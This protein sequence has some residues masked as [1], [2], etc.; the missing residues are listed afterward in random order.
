MSMKGIKS[1]FSFSRKELNGIFLLLMLIQIALMFPFAYRYYYKAPEYDLSGFES[2]VMELHAQIE[3]SK[4]IKLVQNTFVPRCFKFDPNELDEN[5]WKK[6]GVSEGQIKIIL[7]YKARGG[8]FF[9]REDLKR[10]YSISDEQYLKLEP[11]IQI[12]P[13]TISNKSLPAHVKMP[14]SKK[15]MLAILFEINSAD[16]AGLTEIRGIGPAFA[17]RIIR[18]RNRLGGFISKEQL[19]EVYGIDSIKYQQISSQINLDPSLISRININSVTF[20][21]FKHFPYL[22]YKQM[23]AILQYRRQHGQFKTIEDLSKVAIINE[24][25]IRKIEPYISIDP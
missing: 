17:S 10:I 11:Y 23:N 22:S 9:R 3:R 4:N 25:I 8:K 12:K 21:T 18:Y 5:S 19:K 6:L 13:L 16:S 14:H 1:Y 15:M 24:E 7:K 20:D 2:D